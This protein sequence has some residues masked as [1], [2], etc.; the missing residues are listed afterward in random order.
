MNSQRQLRRDLFFPM[1]QPFPHDNRDSAFQE[2]IMARIASAFLLMLFMFAAPQ[3]RAEFLDCLFVDGGFENPG[4]TDPQALAA[5]SLHNCA[6]KTV[7]PPADPPLAPLTWNAAAATVAQTYANGCFDVPSGLPGFGENLFAF[8][9]SDTANTIKDAVAA[10]LAEEPFYS[11]TN[12]KCTE[13]DPPDGSGTCAHYT[14]VVWSTTTQVGCARTFC[15]LHS[16]FGD[17]PHWYFVVCEYQPAGNDGGR[18]Y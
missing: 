11:L 13:L 18:P 17:S 9:A 1:W 10:W 3:A 7:D 12:N 2:E 16:P 8:R 4:T 14:Q 5:L 6:R 15:T